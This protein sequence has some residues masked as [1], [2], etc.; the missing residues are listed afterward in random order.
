RSG[1]AAVS[2]RAAVDCYGLAGASRGTV[3]VAVPRPQWPRLDGVL[4]VHRSTDLCDDHVVV[5]HGIRITNP[6]RT[7]V[8]FA[9]VAGPAAVGRAYDH[10][11]G[12]HLVTRGTVERM[13]A[14]LS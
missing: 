5:R 7:L 10:A 6:M 1:G 3:E 4:Q 13:V 2:T 12:K 11:K 8:A 9:A 14:E